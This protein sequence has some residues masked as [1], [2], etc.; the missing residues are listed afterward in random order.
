VPE[1]DRVHPRERDAA[2]RIVAPAD[3]EVMRKVEKI[4]ARTR[5]GR[6]QHHQRVQLADRRVLFEHGVLLRPA[7]ALEERHTAELHSNGIIGALN[8]AFA[9]DVPEASWPPSVRGHPGARHRCRL[10]HAA[11]GPS[12]PHAAVAGE[13]ARRSSQ[14]PGSVLRSGASARSTAPMCAGVRGHR[15][16]QGAEV[17][18]PISDVNTTLGALLGSSYVNDFN[19]L[20][21]STGLRP[22]EPEYRTTETARPVLRAQREGRHGAARHRGV[23]AA[24]DR[25]EFTN[26]FNLYRAAE[27]SGVPAE[28]YS[29]HRPWRPCGRSRPRRCLPTWVT[30]GDM[31][32]QEDR[33]VARATFAVAI[34]LVFLV[35][36][37]STR[38]G[39]CRS[40]SCWGRR[41]RRS[42]LFRP[43]AR[44]AHVDELREQHLRQIGLIMLIGLAAK[45]AILIVEFAKM[46]HEQGRTS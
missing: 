31:S 12:R 28:G 39:R 36:A 21:A 15:P 6:L 30:S 11:A 20:A 14:P 19:R 13:Q 38:A 41:S 26:R 1:E 7:E 45:N 42:G 8:R 34:L 24:D 35:L 22:G 43:L 9:K 29:S 2:R 27:I 32:Y 3:D 25:S 5:C 18:V 37:P 16:E 46:L 40:A 4:L 44:A 10:H 23:D 17:G 33:A